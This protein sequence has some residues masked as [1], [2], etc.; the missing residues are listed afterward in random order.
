LAESIQTLIGWREWVSLPKL[1]L[2]LIKAKIDTGAKTSSLHA[3]DIEAFRDARG[4]LRVRFKVQPLQARDDLVVQ[5]E[6]KVFDYRL[7]S[8]SGGHREKRYV[9]QT[10][11]QIGTRLF[12]TEVTLAN[13]ASMAHRMLIGRSSLAG[14]LIDPSRTYLLGGRTA[15]RKLY[16]KSKPKQK[17][18]SEK[19]SL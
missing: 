18:R 7:I 17:P 14:F 13:R 1:G 9:I 15:A 19:S 4:M 8:D 10:Q 16:R 3:F 11:T 2:P 5:C 6:S 12:L